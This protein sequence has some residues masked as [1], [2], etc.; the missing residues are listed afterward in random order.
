MEPNPTA[1]TPEPEPPAPAAAGGLLHILGLGF[2][3]A[4]AVGGSMGAGI[5]RTPG[6][7]AAQ[8]GS[9]PL[10]LL[11]WLVGGLYALCGAFAVAELGAALPRAGGWTIYAR[12]ALG[13]RAGFAVGWIDWL[14]HCAGLAWVAIT[15]GEFARGLVPALPPGGKAVALF[16][17]VGFALLQRLGLRAGSLSQ[18]ILSLLKAVAFL[19]LIGA[20]LLVA[21]PAASTSAPLMA[22][23]GT[24]LALAAAGV[25]ALQAV[26]TTYDGWQS[27][28][29]FAEEF[30]APATDLPRSLIGG[31]VAVTGVYLLVNVALLKVLPLE[32]MAA[33]TLPLADAAA[34]LF[35]PFSAQLITALA[36]LSSIGLVNT[37]IMCAPRILF[38]LS[39]DGLFLPV[40]ARVNAGGTPDAALLLTTAVT[41]TL[42]LCGDFQ[43]LLGVSVFF[44]VLLYFTGIT[45]L[46]LLRWREPELERPVRAWGYPLS[47]AVVWL[48]SLAF[49]IS[50]A[51][52]DSTNSLIAAGLIAL[53]LPAQLLSRRMGSPDCGS[54]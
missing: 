40:F 8:L 32:A 42:I 23:S 13:D 24:P 27:P 31:V 35:G 33:S 20:C 17:L 15:I 19:A 43:L 10:I 52:G 2:G 54:G 51:I 26:I 12:R 30:T 36:L 34:R 18:Q 50:A 22:P 11:A 9:A 1:R 37:V 29:Y 48:G 46:F 25:F 4:G 6:L 7:V 49:L 3:L 41:A 53:S 39:R 28:I 14:G 47:A 16:T 5:L 21:P 38:G 44:Y 45:S